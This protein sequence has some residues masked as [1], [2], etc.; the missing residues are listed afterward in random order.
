MIKSILKYF[1]IT[2]L[3]TLLVVGVIIG[4]C[5][6]IRTSGNVLSGSSML[7]KKWKTNFIPFRD[8][9]VYASTHLI[10]L[11]CKKINGEPISEGVQ[12]YAYYSIDGVST[13]DLVV[14]QN[15][16]YFSENDIV[17]ND[18]RV[19]MPSG[20]SQDP[21]TDWTVTKAEFYWG[22]LG[23]SLTINDP[24]TYGTNIFIESAFVSDHNQ[25]TNYLRQ[26]M[27]KG[28]KELS[29]E[30][31]P[32]TISKGTGQQYTLFRLRLYFAECS[33]IVWDCEITEL[34]GEY[35]ARL[36][37]PRYPDSY[38]FPYH[39]PLPDEICNQIDE[40]LKTFNLN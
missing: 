17:T 8:D 1:L 20:Y 28:N 3:V 5:K 19:K 39:F 13:E 10:P 4:A 15:Y 30:K 25:L 40:Y 22:A 36:E 11:S 2:V 24:W 26:C 27:M 18:V 32:S 29:F 16:R 37:I 33:N 7:Y 35:F 34:N 23:Y 14:E 9:Y 21:L 6:V 12:N 31:Y 38:F